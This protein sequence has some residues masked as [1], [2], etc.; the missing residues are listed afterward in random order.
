MV[1]RV[2]VDA[3]F[4]VFLRT[5]DTASNLVREIPDAEDD[6]TTPGLQNSPH[7]FVQRLPL[8]GAPQL[9]PALLQ[10]PIRRVDDDE[11]DALV[12]QQFQHLDTISTMQRISTTLALGFV[13]TQKL[14]KGVREGF[15]SWRRTNLRKDT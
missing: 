8:F 6:E 14:L 7:L 5:Q 1:P 10:H 9:I 3:D 15:H 13:V 12:W 4:L 2:V 11:V